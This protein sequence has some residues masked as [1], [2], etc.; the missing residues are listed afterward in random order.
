MWP[1]PGDVNAAHAMSSLTRML[2]VLDL[3]T[4]DHPAW[5]AEEIAQHLDCS[6]PTAYRYLRELSD[7]QL[8][9][10]AST[11]RY[12]LGTK[13]IELDYQLRAADP[14]IQAG[15]GPMKELARQVDCD[16]ALVTLS[17]THLLTVH[18]EASHAEMR[19]SYGRG[20]RMPTFKGAMSLALL[21]SLGKPQLRKLYQANAQEA[22]AT[23]GAQNLDTLGESLKAIRK[24][25]YAVSQGA[26]DAQNAG[27]AIALLIPEHDIVAS[28]GL[29]LSAERLRLLETD[30]A[31]EWLR[32]C[33]QHIDH[34]LKSPPVRY[35][36]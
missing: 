27:I 1:C 8:L 25:G 7:V 22:A 29:V 6:L 4:P 18:Y 13:I 34:H 20:R 3:F 33:A 19:A 2:S 11:G 31:A 15:H 36:A 14:L 21:S 26:L 23:P 32:Q 10:T 5:T 35:A 30:K 24:Q 12:V 16:V 28:L 9:R 17:G